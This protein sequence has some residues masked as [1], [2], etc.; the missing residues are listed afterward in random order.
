MCFYRRSVNFYDSLQ[1]ASPSLLVLLDRPHLPTHPYAE[2]SFTVHPASPTFSSLSVP[3][4][5]AAA[6]PKCP[7]ELD[8]CQR[9]A[10][11][12]GGRPFIRLPGCRLPSPVFRG[13]RMICGTSNK[14]CLG[15]PLVRLL[16]CPVQSRTVDAPKIINQT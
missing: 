14:R 7:M 10:P 11:G 3:A 5:A 13:L 8:S 4:A 2:L 12:A 16:S 9:R 6:P 1:R 15:R